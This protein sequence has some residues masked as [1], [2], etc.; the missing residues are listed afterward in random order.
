MS[1]PCVRAAL[2]A[3][4]AVFLLLITSS[5][6]TSPARADEGSSV[7]VTVGAKTWDT[8]WTSWDTV[9]ARSLATGAP[10]TVVQPVSNNNHFAVI[11]Q[12][13]LRYGDWLG[14]ASYF[15]QTSYDLSGA[16]DPESGK[17][18]PIS[19]SRWE[20][21]AN[22]GY[23]ILPSVALTVGY[24]QIQ[25]TFGPSSKAPEAFRWKGP[26]VGLSASSV[27]RSRLGMYATVGVGF[28][29]LK[30][31]QELHDAAG[32]TSFDALYTLGEAGLSYSVPTPLSSLSFT[33]TLG[34]RV[35]L[36]TTESYSLN[37]GFSN[38]RTQVDVHDTTH[39]PALTLVARW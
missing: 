7:Q 35:Q 17:S 16:I 9:P 36:V 13:G 25:Q 30:V 23:Y 21:D 5:L 28:L 19:A 3:I 24:K 33:M 34:Y 37:N 1:C 38:G 39:G 6:L 14:S 32:K 18:L 2:R 15:G 29:R 26:T 20:F 12:I 11:P 10:V 22:A 27:L 4:V 31:N 8:Q